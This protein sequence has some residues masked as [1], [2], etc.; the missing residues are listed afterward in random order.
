MAGRWAMS[1]VRWV[2]SDVVS[3]RSSILR[4]PQLVSSSIF[5]WPRLSSFSFSIVDDVL[6]S[7]ISAFESVALVSMLCFFFLFCGCTF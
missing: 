1:A 2:A 4:W 5:E 7:L 6:W 3:F